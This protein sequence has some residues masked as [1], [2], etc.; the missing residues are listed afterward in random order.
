MASQRRARA[1]P[2]VPGLSLLPMTEGLIDDITQLCPTAHPYEEFVHFALPVRDL[3]SSVSRMGPVAYVEA[4]YFGGVGYQAAIV[5]DRGD[6]AQGPVR[7]SRIGPIN[8]ALRLLGVR[9]ELGKDE[10][11]T[12]RLGR[13]RHLEDWTNVEAQT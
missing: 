2:L 4:E 10:F 1:V 11:D 12:V 3:V 13:Y 7:S 9:A 8:S 5:F 6:V